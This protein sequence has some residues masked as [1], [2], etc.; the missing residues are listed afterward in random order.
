M[1]YRHS[2]PQL[3]SVC[4]AVRTCTSTG[5]CTLLENGHR[6]APVVALLKR[7]FMLSSCYTYTGIRRRLRACCLS[8]SFI[9]FLLRGNSRKSDQGR[10]IS[11]V[12]NRRADGGIIR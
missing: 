3:F 6:L 4:L 8:P 7:L 5:T 2:K 11:L 9:A 10:R 1:R 12:W